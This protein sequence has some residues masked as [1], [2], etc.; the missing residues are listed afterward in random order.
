MEFRARLDDPFIHLTVLEFCFEHKMNHLDCKNNVFD[1]AIYLQRDLQQKQEFG[2]RLYLIP[3]A[4]LK[5]Y[6]L[7]VRKSHE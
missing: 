1:N 3:V 5:Y 4:D 2:K 6:F 7:I